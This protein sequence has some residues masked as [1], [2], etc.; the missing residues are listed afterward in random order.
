MSFDLATALVPGNGTGE[1][2]RVTLD[3]AQSSASFKTLL[4][5][6][7]PCWQDKL[8]SSSEADKWLKSL[9][10]LE[11]DVFFAWVVKRARVTL[12]SDPGSWYHQYN[13]VP[14][15]S[16]SLSYYLNNPGGDK[17]TKGYCQG[18]DTNPKEPDQPR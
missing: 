1:V 14:G 17:D 3:L 8:S 12:R 7:A 18:P 2:L 5:K 15:N 13:A 16:F 9:D 10:E 4:A 11:T 6:V